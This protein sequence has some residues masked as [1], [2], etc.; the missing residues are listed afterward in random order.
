MHCLKEMLSL[1]RQGAVNIVMDA[2]DE[3]SNKP[4][5]SSP[6]EEVLKVMEQLVGL[7]PPGLITG[8][9][10]VIIRNALGLLKSHPVSLHG[11][12]GQNKKI[13]DYIT[14]VV[15]SDRRVRRW[16][17]ED[18][19]LVIE[20]LS[21]KADGMYVISRE[22]TSCFLIHLLGSSRSV[23]C[24]L[25]T[26]RRCFPPS[27]RQDLEKS[28]VILDETYERALLGIDNDKSE[29]ARRFFQCLAVSVP[30]LCSEELAEAIVVNLKNGSGTD[31]R[32]GLAP[33]RHPRKP[34]FAHAPA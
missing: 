29:Y 24:Q 26:L 2:L 3:C 8:L 30:P 32:R 5:M 7:R 27:I 31:C 16:K 23:Y 20:S 17:D 6:R 18:K 22:Y 34:F 25:E 28:P 11:E 1:S 19:N 9:P 15:R 13:I 33:A 21:V 4:G 10:E 14:S 12:C